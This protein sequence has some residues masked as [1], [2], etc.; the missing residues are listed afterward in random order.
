MAALRVLVPHPVVQRAVLL[1]EAARHHDDLGDGKFNDRTRVGE[2]CVEHD[3]APP[4][5]VREVDLVRA[6]AEGPDRLQ[7]GRIVE[8]ARAHLGLGADAEQV[9]ALQRLDQ[10]VLVHRADAHVDLE[11]GLAQQRLPQGVHVLEQQCLHG[12]FLSL[13]VTTT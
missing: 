7:V 8:H 11:A 12:R 13:A 9:D 1:A 3:D 4:R 10:L 5:G 2:R 6:D